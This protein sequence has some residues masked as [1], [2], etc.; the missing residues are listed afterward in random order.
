MK[1]LPSSA[2]LSSK[3]RFRFFF[4]FLVSSPDLCDRGIH[5]QQQ[6]VGSMITHGFRGSTDDLAEEAGMDPEGKKDLFE[7]G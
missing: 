5:I 4:F 3:S 1:T 7:T 2:S 6:I